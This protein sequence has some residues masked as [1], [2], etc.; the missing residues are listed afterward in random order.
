MRLMT[1][2]NEKAVWRAVSTGNWGPGLREHAAGCAVCRDVALVTRG[3]ADLARESSDQ[4]LLPDPHQI[5]WRA[6]W[7]ESKTA[8]ERAVRPIVVYQ[9]AAAAAAVL[10]LGAAG[11]WSWSWLLQWLP[12]WAATPIVLG[13]LFAFRAALAED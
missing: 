2:P 13:A 5:W 7:I 1:C 10:C 4:A 3:L 9:R 11:L 12:L 6:R 8:S